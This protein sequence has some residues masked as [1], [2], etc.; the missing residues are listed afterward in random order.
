MLA[1]QVSRIDLHF[2]PSTGTL[3]KILQNYVQDLDNTIQKLDNLKT[4]FRQNMYF[5]I[6]ILVMCLVLITLVSDKI[7]H[8]EYTSSDIV[9][10]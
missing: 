5:Y 1:K 6:C 3:V 10:K 8:L 2:L 7:K 9:E 4:A